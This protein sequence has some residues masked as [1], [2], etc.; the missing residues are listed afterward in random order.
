MRLPSP[1][2]RI[3]TESGEPPTKSSLAVTEELTALFETLD[4]VRPGLPGALRCVPRGL[5]TGDRRRPPAP[6]P[7]LR[8]AAAR[9]SCLLIG[10]DSTQRR[11]V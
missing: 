10:T 6:E 4:F 9:E 3:T 8:P 1:A 7:R 2:A 11:T 5:C